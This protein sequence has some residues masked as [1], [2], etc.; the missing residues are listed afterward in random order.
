MVFTVIKTYWKC[1]STPKSR[2][3]KGT[4]VEMC[5]AIVS[6]NVTEDAPSAIFSIFIVAFPEVFAKVNSPQFLLA[7]KVSN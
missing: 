2:N 5:L 1:I 7:S 3:K 4:G 6:S